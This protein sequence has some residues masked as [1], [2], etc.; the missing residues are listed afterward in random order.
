MSDHFGFAYFP[1]E[2]RVEVTASGAQGNDYIIDEIRII[3]AKYGVYEQ[4]RF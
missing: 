2:E 3:D 4:G 1:G